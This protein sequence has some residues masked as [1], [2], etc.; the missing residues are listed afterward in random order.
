MPE[1]NILSMC[2]LPEHRSS[3]PL[4]P[5]EETYV[6]SILY[7]DHKLARYIVSRSIDLSEKGLSIEPYLQIDPIAVQSDAETLIPIPGSAMSPGGMLV[8]GGGMC[9]FI[10]TVAPIK[11]TAK[12]GKRRKSTGGAKQDKSTEKGEPN[13]IVTASVPIEKPAA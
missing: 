13:R 2:F 12:L 5:S 4:P 10:E 6:L 7:V 3:S 8:F 11:E 9:Q 1:F